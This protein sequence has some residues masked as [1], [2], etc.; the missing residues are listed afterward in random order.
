[1][2][3][4]FFTLLFI[5]VRFVHPSH[6]ERVKDSI[7]QWSSDSVLWVF[8]WCYGAVLCFSGC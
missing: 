3:F 8:T 7:M 1:M 2:F 4:V 6:T 5:S